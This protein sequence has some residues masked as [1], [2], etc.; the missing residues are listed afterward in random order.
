M[1][2]SRS[3][4]KQI[5]NTTPT[6]ASD[7][8]ES[9]RSFIRKAAAAAAAASAPG[10]FKTP[11][12]G[13]NQA[14]SPGRVLGA[15]DRINVAYVGTGK[16]GMTHVRLQKKFADS[17]NVAQVA[18]CDLYEK[19]LQEARAFTGLTDA[20]AFGDHRRLLERKDIDAVLVATV[21][22]WH[23][24][25]TIDALEAGKHVFCEKPMTRYLAEAFDVHDAVKRA[26]KV[27]VVGS[28]GR[29]DPKW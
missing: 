13:Q 19:H 21:D 29:M 27:Y 18:V 16:Q 8:G 28:Q 3:L 10:L 5:M 23:A 25:V 1:P 7:A 2:G 4:V 26:G 17:N 14:P 24:Q 11:V 9:R 6:P 22:N 20:D 12:Y 15:N